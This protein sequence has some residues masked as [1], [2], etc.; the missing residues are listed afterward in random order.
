MVVKD[1]INIHGSSINQKAN[2]TMSVMYCAGTTFVKKNFCLVARIV[3]FDTV[4]LHLFTFRILEPYP[5]K[6][7]ALDLS[8]VI[9]H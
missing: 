4:D 6:D 9:S 5:S 2:S 7:N 3:S 8:H 1:R